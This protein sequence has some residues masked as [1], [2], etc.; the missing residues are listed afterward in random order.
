MS[1]AQASI[2]SVLSAAPSCGPFLFPTVT[3]LFDENMVLIYLMVVVGVAFYESSVGFYICAKN[4]SSTKVSIKKILTVPMVHA[5]A[6][7]LLWNF[8]NLTVPH[9]LDDFFHNVRNMYSTVGMFIIGISVSHISRISM[10]VKFILYAIGLKMLIQPLVFCI[11]IT[12]DNYFLHWYSWEYYKILVLVAISPIS[13]GMIFLAALVGFAVETVITAVL[14]SI[15]LELL[16]L[17][18]V[19]TIR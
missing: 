8:S 7:G 5:F 4:L 16:Y 12:I 9:F 10:D 14:V 17:P 11:F 1:N 6:I 2:L 15:L 19:L 18:T 3:D 13:G